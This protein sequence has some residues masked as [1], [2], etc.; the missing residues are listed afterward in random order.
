MVLLFECITTT[1]NMNLLHKIHCCVTP[2]AKMNNEILISSRD[3][4][5]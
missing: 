4:L 5:Q 2:K 3:Q 1:S